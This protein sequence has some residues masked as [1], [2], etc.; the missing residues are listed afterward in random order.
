MGG[1]YDNLLANFEAPMPA[2][3]FSISVSALAKL[4]LKQGRVMPLEAPEVLVFG[5]EGY[6]MKAL[7]FASELAEKGRTWRK[8]RV[9]LFERERRVCGEEGNP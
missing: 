1:R 6:E 7:L 2:V 3:G 8:F 5:R 4:M 9:F